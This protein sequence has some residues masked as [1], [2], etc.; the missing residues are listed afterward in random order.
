MLEKATK[1][2]HPQASCEDTLL[3]K[4]WRDKSPKGIKTGQEPTAQPLLWKILKIKAIVS[5]VVNSLIMNTGVARQ[6]TV[7]G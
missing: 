1:N 5:D 7:G 3:I 2:R 6:G 4:S